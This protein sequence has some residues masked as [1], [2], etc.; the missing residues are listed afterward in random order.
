ML[1]LRCQNKTNLDRNTWQGEFKN[2]GNTT[3]Q[4]SPKAESKTDNT[5]LRRQDSQNVCRP[6]IFSFINYN[7]SSGFV[8]FFKEVLFLFAYAED[9]VV[10]N[11]R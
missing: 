8:W 5:L 1:E 6:W 10:F 7:Q 11:Q 4:Q 9:L 2:T 3:H